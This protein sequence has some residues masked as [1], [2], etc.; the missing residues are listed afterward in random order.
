M[1]LSCAVVEKEEGTRNVQWPLFIQR[2][3]EV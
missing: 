3:H 1:G 2:Q